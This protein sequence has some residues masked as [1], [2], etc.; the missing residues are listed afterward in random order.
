MLRLAWRVARKDLLLTLGRGSGLVQGL[1]LGLLLLFV[2]SL[3]QG[4]GERMSPQGAAA[5]FW[6]SA[7]F[8]Q[9]LVFNGLYALEEANAARLGLLLAPAPVQGVWLGKGLAGLL[10]LLLAQLLF[11]P[12]AVIFLGQEPCGPLGPGLLALL[13]VDLGICA[14]GSL[15]GALAQGGTRESLLSIVLFPLLVPLLLAGI[16][17]GAQTFG[18][19][20]PDGPAAWLQLAAAFDAVFLAAGLLLFGFMYAGDE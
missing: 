2:F 16:R 4:V 12:A 1:L 18:L 7:L 6:L 14:L 9:V 15:L 5:I 20:D 8:C 13:L 17:V 11:L 3:S 10:L 19:D